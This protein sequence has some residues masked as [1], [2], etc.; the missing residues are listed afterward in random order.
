MKLFGPADS[1]VSLEE[2]E[3]EKLINKDEHSK[4]S[5]FDE[6]IE[7]IK[8]QKESEKAVS[9]KQEP[10]PAENAAQALPPTSNDPGERI[11]GNSEVDESDSPVAAE[12]PELSDE[13]ADLLNAVKDDSPKEEQI[14]TEQLREVLSRQICAVI[15]LRDGNDLAYES[16]D[17]STW[18]TDSSMNHNSTNSTLWNFTKEAG[19]WLGQ[20]GIKLG[21]D[22]LPKL[23][24]HLY[25]G[26]V[27][28]FNRLGYGF[29]V[30]LTA[31]DQYLT[32][33][34]NSFN[35][36]HEEIQKA[37]QA[38]ELLKKDKPKDFKDEFYTDD[39]NINQLSIGSSVNLKDNLDTLT[40]FVNSTMQDLGLCIKE[41][42]SSIEQLISYSHLGGS[43]DLLDLLVL[44]P[45]IKNLVTGEIDGYQTNSRLV[46]SYHVKTMLPGNTVLICHLPSPES[47]T[48]EEWIQA[49][50]ESDMFLG[51][52]KSNFHLTDQISYLN[53]NELSDVL[54]KLETL[55]RACIGH[56]SFYENM[57]KQK[58]HQRLVYKN[59]FD[60]IVRRDKKVGLKES[61]IDL[62]TMKNNFVDKVYLPAAI[63]VHDYAVRIINAYLKLVAKNVEVLS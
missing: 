42:L 61:L 8:D 56:Q 48:R 3:L 46:T 28:A 41:D 12:K 51:V 11:T 19:K 29:A 25:K 1:I 38:V 58:L 40:K 23:A 5:V 18:S 47:K 9:D 57:K 63:D 36:L 21:T 4:N 54:N 22:T 49:Y 30:G 27:Y 52:V 62:V 2:L 15:S 59:Y 10:E 60:S 35:R 33:R 44:K 31:L 17:D 24:G 45:K 32:R 20:L 34:I 26:I 16:Y 55:C 14:S 37:K 13:D 53:A 6:L 7:E 50:R 43:K 39:K